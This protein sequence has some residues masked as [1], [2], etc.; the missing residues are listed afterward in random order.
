MHTEAMGPRPAYVASTFREQDIMVLE[1]RPM[2][3]QSYILTGHVYAIPIEFLMSFSQP[4][5]HRLTAASYQR[6]RQH[7]NLPEKAWIATRMYADGWAPQWEFGTFGPFIPSTPSTATRT[8]SD[9][10]LVEK[11]MER[12]VSFFFSSLIDL[13]QLTD[14]F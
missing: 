9:A 4:W 11:H 8:L 10:A 2:L 7:L 1:N 6:L 12:Q 3:K 14:C 5:E 13:K